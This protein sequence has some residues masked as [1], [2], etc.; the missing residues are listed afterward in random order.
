MIDINHILQS[1]THTPFRHT[2]PSVSTYKYI[3]IKSLRKRCT[4]SS[5]PASHYTPLSI[6][7]LTSS[8]DHSLNVSSPLLRCILPFFQNPTKPYRCSSLPLLT[9]KPS[10]L[11]H[12]HPPQTI[13][14]LT[15]ANFLLITP[16]TSSPKHSDSNFLL[17]TLATSSSTHS[18]SLL[19]SSLP[20]PLC[21][22]LQATRTSLTLSDTL[23]ALIPS[24]PPPF[25]SCPD[26]Y[27]PNP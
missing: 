2:L 6:H 26:P 17:V 21:P 8:P 13:L 16:A 24:S 27:Q 18:D 15:F 3:N 23:P 12:H 14:N 1:I 25:L 11:P 20:T 10:S 9:D 19:L 4:V 7:T 22:S 5:S